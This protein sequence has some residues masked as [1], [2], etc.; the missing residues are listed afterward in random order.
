MSIDVHQ[1]AAMSRRDVE[2][3]T[4]IAPAE[5]IAWAIVDG[6]AFHIR[7]VANGEDA[8]HY[9]SGF[10]G[11]GYVLVKGTVGRQKLFKFLV[12]QQALQLNDYCDFD[13]IAGLVT[14]GVVPAYE[15]REQLQELQDREIPYVYIRDTRKAGGT[16]EHVTGIQDLASGGTNPEIPEGSTGVVMEEL[17]N[18]SN[19][20][21]NGARV[22]RSSG[23]TCNVGFTILDY[24]HDQGRQALKE[25]RLELKRLITL[26]DLID[27]IEASE[28]FEQRLVDDY[29]WFQRDTA[30]WMAHYGYEK[31]EHGR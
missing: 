14:G 3:M 12:R 4:D 30:G 5:V 29:R 7:D 13:F 20:V 2:S 19:S 21:S 31:K 11:P 16:R 10:F 27:A 8:Y 9:S 26:S 1:Y 18:F 24:N 15:L 22:L 17:T 6:G 28:A 25:A 23:Y